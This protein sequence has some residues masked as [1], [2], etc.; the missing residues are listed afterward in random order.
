LVTEDVVVGA[1]DMD[2]MKMTGRVFSGKVGARLEAVE[3]YEV[4]SL[5][6][7]VLN[8]GTA[9]AGCWLPW[10]VLLAGTLT[11]RSRPLSFEPVIPHTHMSRRSAFENRP[12]LQCDYGW[13]LVK[14]L[15]NEGI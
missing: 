12:S 7:W 13:S 2:F 4:S 11:G 10:P 8:P 9:L 15:S 14:S 5:P 6:Y 1:Y 3:Y